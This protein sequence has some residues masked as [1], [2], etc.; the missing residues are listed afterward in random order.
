MNNILPFA[1]LKKVL[2]LKLLSVAVFYSLVRMAVEN[3]KKP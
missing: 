1:Y 2:R 3:I